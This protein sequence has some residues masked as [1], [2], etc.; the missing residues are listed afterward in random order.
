MSFEIGKVSAEWCERAKLN[1]W[2]KESTTS[3][4]D[5]AKEDSDPTSIKL[6]FTDEQTLGRGRGGNSWDMGE[7]GT[8][9][10]SS[11]C[12][13]SSKN[14]QPVLAPLVGLALYRACKAT[15]PELHFSMKAPNDLFLKDKKVAGLL[16]ENIQQGNKN[17]V[18]I[19]L[20]VNVFSIPAIP[21]A[22]RLNHELEDITPIEWC[23]F[24]DRL[25]LE[26]TMTI[27]SMPQELSTHQ[28]NALLWALNQN[29]T[30]QECYTNV[31][32]NG[33]LKT[34]SKTIPWSVQ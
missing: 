32:A 3:T 20:G 23:Q 21:F 8:A 27:S 2:Y 15:W 11:W 17:K 22:T 33:D 4:N 30:L 18:V 1:F 19:G 10:L 14:P 24:L 25:L 28:R 6:Y 31:E 7:K 29:P 26:F 13:T 9:L 12:F 16:I 34:E 5:I